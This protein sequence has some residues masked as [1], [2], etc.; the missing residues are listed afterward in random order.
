MWIFE[1][2]LGWFNASPP[3][4][5]TIPGE[6]ARTKHSKLFIKSKSSKAFLKSPA[7]LQFARG[8]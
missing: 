7:K 5:I 8:R 4:V 2:P 1:W 6:V 3:I